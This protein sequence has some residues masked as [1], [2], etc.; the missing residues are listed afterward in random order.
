MKFNDSP[1][2]PLILA[3]GIF[4]FLAPAGMVTQL[5]ALE[6]PEILPATSDSEASSKDGAKPNIILIFADD[7]GYNDL[8]CFG[9][10]KI[11]TP[12]VDRLAKEGMRFTNFYSAASVCTPSRAALLT[13][14][15]PERVGNLPVLF[16]RSNR[17]LN[18]NETTVAE[19]LKGAG[20]K[21]ACVG[22]W[23]L[24]HHKTFLPTNHGF[25]HYFGIP[26][27]NDMNI[28][29]T[30]SVAKDVNWRDNMTMAKFKSGKS[31][32]PPLMRGNQVIECPA[33]QTTLTERYTENAIKF[34][35]TT[36]KTEKPFFLYL[37]HTMPHIPLY[38]SD[39]FRGTSQAGLYGDTIEE[40]DW[41][42]GEIVKTLK[43]LKLD[44]N[45]L[46]VYTSDN[47]PWDLKNNEKSWEKGNMNRRV[48]GSAFPLKG[49]K[50]SRWEG[51]M[52]EPTVM[53]WPKKIKPD[54]ACDAVAGTIDLLPTFAKISGAQLPEMKID[55]KPIDGLFEN[56]TGKSP[57][58]A[59][60]YRTIAVRVGDWKLFERKGKQELYNLA[61]D[62]G[63]SKN[64]ASE[65]P[66][67]VESLSKLLKAHIAEL[68]QNARKPG[69]YERPSE[70]VDGLKG[71]RSIYGKWSFKEGIL[72]QSDPSAESSIFST[73]L[74]DKSLVLE[75]DAKITSGNEA[76]RIM[77]RA[78]NNTNYIRWSTGAFNNTLHSL[79]LV[80]SGKILNRTKPHKT[81]MEK[82]RW[83]R[84]KIVAE[85]NLV[86]C[87]VDGD[88][89]NTQTFQF[90]QD[91]A[92][93]LG[94]LGTAVQFRNLKVTA[95]GEVKLE[96]PK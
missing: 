71:W 92:I 25:D 33:D 57:H 60:F 41:S 2:L 30:M 61:T 85:G 3:L 79:M 68:K 11:K 10:K 36:A 93:G 77:I 32:G 65:N 74:S 23:H 46:I 37:P 42:V 6:Q 51:G 55:G 69:N 64:V 56:P 24:G 75:V 94:S 19:M 89:T 82:D 78:R 1:A 48:G 39:K 87:Y 67:V 88:L 76:F 14:C 81:T 90:R 73:Q 95:G 70:R 17:G 72:T 8:G 9:S 80:R 86:K 29:A 38:A 96:F 84:L 22:K 45:T 50:F 31:N 62:V 28:D 40:L 13:G 63:E 66:K 34:I 18:P 16:P 43:R 27:S 58:Q 7:Q 26:Y 83:Y 59:Y 21:T 5:I 35:S 49:Y 12:N 53:W 54:S 44:E 20:Y 52:R 47:G 4:A 15:Y 91:G